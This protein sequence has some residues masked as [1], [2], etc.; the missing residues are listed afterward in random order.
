MTYIPQE[1]ATAS[2]LPASVMAFLVIP[3]GVSFV[4]VSIR[5]S[6]K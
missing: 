1:M 2:Q 4:E 3:L 5:Y 6:G